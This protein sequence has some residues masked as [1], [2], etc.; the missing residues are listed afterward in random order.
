MT[1]Q[2]VST[3]TNWFLTLA[4]T[5]AKGKTQTISLD[6]LKA[7]LAD[8]DN[9]SSL[10]KICSSMKAKSKLPKNV[11][12]DPA[13]PARPQSAW[14]RF[15]HHYRTE[16]PAA[17]GEGATITAQGAALWKQLKDTPNPYTKAYEKDK[18]AY[19]KKMESY[20][21]PSDEELLQDTANKARM[22]KYKAKMDSLEEAKKQG[23]I[24]PKKG[25]N[26]Y[27][28]FLQNAK[29]MEKILAENKDK[30]LK[31]ATV[32]AAAWKKLTESKLPA[33]IKL[34]A[35]YK[36]KAK[37]AQDAY[38]AAKVAY[39][40][41]L[42]AAFPNLK[43]GSASSQSDS[44]ESESAN[45]DEAE[46]E[47]DEEKVEEESTNAEPE[48]EPAAEPEPEAEKPTASPI[49]KQLEQFKALLLDEDTP[50]RTYESLTTAEK[51]K[52]LTALKKSNPKATLATMDK[53]SVEMKAKMVAK[54]ITA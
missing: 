29:L 53:Q 23:I 21:R 4:T 38:K 25:G 43:K 35:E 12:K 20:V 41:K 51:N 32:K 49:K 2:N 19:E 39:D 15:M 46:P 30:T 27:T 28:F 8:E 17:K 13:A 33:D 52:I 10:K 3:I 40:A 18:I 16:N 14:I 50:A 22:E 34:V 6:S 9:V 26:A 37:V 7:A 47:A 45:D 31:P 44:D 1:T 36:K 11:L 54:Y 24:P 5:L 42:K 48:D